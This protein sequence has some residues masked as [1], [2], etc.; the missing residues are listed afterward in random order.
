MHYYKFNIADYRKDTTHLNP[1]EHYIYR[2]LIDWYYLDEHPI[3]KETQ[4]VIRRLSL[5][6]DMVNL[7]NNVLSDFFVLGENGYVHSR[8]ERD[9]VEYNSSASKNKANGKLGGRPPKPSTEST[10][11]QSVNLA[12]PNES[13]LNPNHKP[14]TINHEPTHIGS[15]C[16]AIKKEYDLQNMF[17][18]DMSQDNPSFIACIEA[19]AT[20]GEFVQA[21]KISASK[22]KGF[23]YLVSIVIKQRQEATNL[24]LHKGKMPQ[25]VN[26]EQGRQIAANSIF[27]PEHIAHLMGNNIKEV[28]E[29]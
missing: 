27:K 25:V 8:I 23:R 21:A 9:I 16:V 7:L 17:I 19:G 12:N 29:I 14:L 4:S 15:V 20:V 11:T 10:E 6:S 2:S 26:R 5:G 1:T 28:K 22:G 24:N 13:E 18:L 3:P